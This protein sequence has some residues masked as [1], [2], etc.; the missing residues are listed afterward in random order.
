MWTDPLPTKIRGILRQ[1]LDTS[2]GKQELSFRPSSF[3]W[4]NVL[5][6]LSVYEPKFM[7]PK[8]LKYSFDFY[9][10][11]GTAIHDSLQQKRMSIA[12]LS[13][14]YTWGS[15]KCASCGEYHLDEDGFMYEGFCPDK[16]LHCGSEVFDYEELE[17]EYRLPGGRTVLRSHKD[18]VLNI[19][20]TFIIL[21][22]KS[23][24]EDNFLEERNHRYLPQDKHVVQ[25]MT[26]AALLKE[27]RNIDV[28]GVMV[29]YLSRNK[30]PTPEQIVS[31]NTPYIAL[32]QSALKEQ[33]QR[34]RDTMASHETYLDWKDDPTNDDLIKSLWGMRPCHSKS[35]YDRLMKPAFFGK[36]NCPFMARGCCFKNNPEPMTLL[37]QLVSENETVRHSDEV[38]ESTSGK[39]EGKISAWSSKTRPAVSARGKVRRPKS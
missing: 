33:V 26:Y 13:R 10:K 11:V 35:E 19:D 6:A 29:I 7:P 9:V 14:Q 20:G 37:K 4:C 27:V 30:A 3:P 2:A 28:A 17:L 15:W 1:L 18:W 16:C 22:F 39:S 21:D 24:S 5:A 25:V 12:S 38:E 23:T 32:S 8:D 34:L 31:G 36:E